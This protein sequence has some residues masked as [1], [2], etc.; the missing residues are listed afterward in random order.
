MTVDSRNKL[1]RR[2]FLRSASGVA[3]VAAVAAAISPAM[4]TEAEAYDPG[5]DETGAKYQPDAAD[6]QA[7]YRSNGYETLKDK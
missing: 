4:V 1:D 5:P 3:T 7:F 2:G 6:V